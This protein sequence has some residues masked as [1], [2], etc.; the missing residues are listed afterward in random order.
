ML[1]AWQTL[2]LISCFKDMT[3]RRANGEGH[4]IDSEELCGGAREEL[5][6]S[7]TSWTG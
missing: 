2:L 3:Q 1:P 5:A 6:V 7:S 4:P